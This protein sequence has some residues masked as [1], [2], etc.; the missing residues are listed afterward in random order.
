MKI[1]LALLLLIPSLNIKAM[2]LTCL[3]NDGKF[4]A[5]L[6]FDTWRETPPIRTNDHGYYSLGKFIKYF[7]DS[8]GSIEHELVI[9]NQQISGRDVIQIDG[10]T[11]AENSYSGYWNSYVTHIGVSKNLSTTDIILKEGSP[12]MDYIFEYKCN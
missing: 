1:L 5:T 4:Q 11:F 6:I 3:S 12:H 7:T 9:F 2:T 10:Y 8:K